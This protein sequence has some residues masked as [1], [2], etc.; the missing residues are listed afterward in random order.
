M[1]KELEIAIAT[2]NRHMDSQIKVIENGHLYYD[3]FIIGA[4]SGSEK[5]ADGDCWTI[6]DHVRQLNRDNGL[7]HLTDA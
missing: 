6:L 1:L 2:F 5:L 7:N 3:L 4:S